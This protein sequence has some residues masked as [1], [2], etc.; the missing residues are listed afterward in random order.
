[1]SRALLTYRHRR[2]ER[3]RFS[4]QDA[5]RAGAL[6]PWQSGSDGREETQQLHHEPE[7]RGAGCR[8]TRTSST[9]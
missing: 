7:V 6:Y 9:T 2:L 1:M 8:T 3:A 4:A 5:G